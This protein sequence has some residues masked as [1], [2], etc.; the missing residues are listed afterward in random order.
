MGSEN[1]NKRSISDE[2]QPPTLPSFT[3]FIVIQSTIPNTPITS[4]SPFVIEKQLNG[5]VGHPKQ[6][7]KM[8]NGSL[9]VEVEKPAQSKN[10]LKTTT[11]FKIPVQCTPHNTLN[12][13]RGVIRCPDLRGHP[14]NEILQELQEQHVREVKR[15]KI[16]KQQNII[17]TNTFILTFS[18]PEPPKSIKI[19]YLKTPVENY[20]PNPM[21]CRKCQK[22][23][24]TQLKCRQT[25]SRCAKCSNINTCPDIAHCPNDTKCC[26][27][28]G[29][30]VSF[31]K[32]CPK[33][34]LEKQVL[35]IKHTQNIT[36]QEARKA[37]EAKLQTSNT[38]ASIIKST[39]S[40]TIELTD[41]QTQ[42]D[43]DKEI[44]KYEQPPAAR[45]GRGKFATPDPPPVI[46][47]L[48]SA[49]KAQQSAHSSRKSP[50]TGS[51]SSSGSRTSKSASSGAASGAGPLSPRRSQNR[52]PKEKIQT[53]ITDRIPKGSRDP[54]VSE[55]YYESLSYVTD[56]EDEDFSSCGSTRSSPG[57][58][59]KKQKKPKFT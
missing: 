47:P 57:R 32:Q 13:S 11:F 5:I 9:L 54:I 56:M 58:S 15:I 37:A 53:V 8:K 38:Y 49:E 55:N 35:T 4:L 1:T 14:D 12:T 44:L 3:R 43:S 29:N 28:S 42:T 16:T 46:R 7:K 24:H 51:R 26:N 33:W 59:P 34:Q 23:G 20:I 52:A 10:L 40:R 22:F 25:E 27:C 2:H 6:V 48:T 18:S 45:I 36:F 30:H 17:D 19:G 39:Q 41:A 31:S 50:T 21:Q